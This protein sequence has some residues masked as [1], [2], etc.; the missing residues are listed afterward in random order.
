MKTFIDKSVGCVIVNKNLDKVLI[1]RS[2]IHYG[3]P[4]GHI[5]KGETEI[6]TMHREVFE[7]IGLDI[8]NEKILGRFE[9]NFPIFTKNIKRIIVC[10]MI[11][12]D[13]SIPLIIQENELDEALWVSWKEALLLLQNSKQYLILIE[14]IKTILSIKYNSKISKIKNFD[15]ILLV[16][17]FDNSLLLDNY[18]SNNTLINTFNNDYIYYVGANVIINLFINNFDFSLLNIYKLKP[19]YKMFYTKNYVYNLDYLQKK[20][21]GIQFDNYYGILWNTQIA[22]KIKIH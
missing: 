15:K 11:V 21:N 18:I 8:K 22:N 17:K 3:F 19:I 20:Y 16:N 14:A 6:Q 9:I 1:V 5:D 13:D 2:D 12:Y 4:K 7:E 10:Y